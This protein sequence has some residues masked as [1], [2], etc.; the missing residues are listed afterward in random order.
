MAKPGTRGFL[1]A[2]PSRRRGTHRLPARPYGLSQCA[3]GAHNAQ[4]RRLSG[5][6]SFLV[7]H[8]FSEKYTN[9]CAI[10]KVP[11]KTPDFSAALV[12]FAGFFCYNS[13]GRIQRPHGGRK[14]VQCGMNN[15]LPRSLLPGAALYFVV[16]LAFAGAAAAAGHYYTAAVEAGV[17]LAAF[18]DRKSV[19]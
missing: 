12:V 11:G 1:Q 15:Q 18:I 2:A 7:Y 4:F 3:R 5:G 14:E 8:T 19:V 9:I 10:Q 6:S 17:V 13:A 16:M